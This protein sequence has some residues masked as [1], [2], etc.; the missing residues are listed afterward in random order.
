MFAQEEDNGATSRDHADEI[1]NYKEDMAAQTG[2][3][4]VN[5]IRVSYGR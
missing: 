5:L 1:S 3:F 2:C 4:N